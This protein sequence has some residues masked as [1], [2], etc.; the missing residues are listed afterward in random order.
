MLVVVAVELYRREHGDWPKTLNA[1]VP[2]YLPAVPLDRFDG[3]ALKYV[4]RDGQPI[5]YS[6]GSDR[7]DNDGVAPKDESYRKFF[8]Q[9]WRSAKEAAADRQD[10]PD[11][12][13]DWILWPPPKPEPLNGQ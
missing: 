2:E 13:G 8:V 11:W 5:V 9:M 10:H 12:I 4:L 1:L 7:V 3:K 6:I